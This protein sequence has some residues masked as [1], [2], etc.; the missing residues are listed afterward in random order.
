MPFSLCTRGNST[1]LSLPHAAPG[2]LGRWGMVAAGST[3][4]QL[5]FQGPREDAGMQ[6]DRALLSQMLSHQVSNL[7]QRRGRRGSILLLGNIVLGIFLPILKG[8]EQG[9]LWSIL[10]AV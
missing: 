6:L 7:V 4:H 10:G 2:G 1:S 9:L 8:P 3:S 5:A